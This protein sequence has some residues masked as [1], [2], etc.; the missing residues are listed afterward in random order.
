M[1]TNTKLP[2]DY[3]ANIH[4]NISIYRTTYGRKEPII[5]FFK[6]IDIDEIKLSSTVWIMKHMTLKENG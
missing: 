2:I 1:Q 6:D 3:E 5:I 4:E